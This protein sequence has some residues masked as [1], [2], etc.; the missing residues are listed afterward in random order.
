MTLALAL[1]VAL[2]QAMPLRG[3]AQVDKEEITLGEPFTLTVDVEHAA[4]DVYALPDALTVA[5]LALRGA[6][7]VARVPR[8][9]RA[10]TTF[11]IPLADY[12]SL[13]P[14]IPAIQFHVEGP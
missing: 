3:D 11:R 13:D 9:D 12:S 4:L 7:S 10:E 5:P 2:P 14:E 6:P 8:G 1:L